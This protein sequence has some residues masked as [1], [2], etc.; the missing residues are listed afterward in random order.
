MDGSSKY[1]YVLWEEGSSPQ[2]PLAHPYKCLNNALSPSLGAKNVTQYE[3]YHCA[4]VTL[5]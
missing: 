1:C 3:W 2:Y 5:G 4:P